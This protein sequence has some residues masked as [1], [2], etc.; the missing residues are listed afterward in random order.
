MSD[1]GINRSAVREL[2]LPRE[3]GNPATTRMQSLSRPGH[4]KRG[5]PLRGVARTVGRSP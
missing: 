2:A 3:T 1:V 5:R 4:G